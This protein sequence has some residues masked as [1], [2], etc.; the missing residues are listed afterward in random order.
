MNK[1]VGLWLDQN[2][3]FLISITNN[4][5]DRERISAD[6]EHYFRY[7]TNV[8]G[9]GLPEDVRDQ[10]FWRHLNEYYDNLIAFIR[11]AS[12]IQIFGPGEAKY[13]L[14]KRLESAGMLDQIVSVDNADK[15]T[16]HE[17]IL[18]VRERFPARSEFDIS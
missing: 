5:E 1:R 17:V 18:K 7:S 14:Q 9:D 3:A 4:G 15:L 16:D 13:Q 6:M 8:P 12:A 11:G 10:R 2:K